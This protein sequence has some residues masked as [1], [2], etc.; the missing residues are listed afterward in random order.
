MAYYQVLVSVEQNPDDLRQVFTDLGENDLK[1]K[2]VTPY[3]KGTSL[4]CGNEII[5]VPK[6]RKIHIVQTS[7]PNET[8]RK[9]LNTKSI[10]KI[11][12]FN[13]ESTSIVWISAGRGYDPLD[14]LEAGEDV[15]AKCL[16]WHP[17]V[18][19]GPSYLGRF[20]HNPWVVAV[21]GGLVVMFIGLKLGWNK[22]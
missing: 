16:P 12:Q 7:R 8:E 22:P 2:L 18:A 6:I 10:R 3:K 20:I 1:S 9:E 11:D 4:I 19:S 21:I 5:P 15:T 14:I 17:G 13:R